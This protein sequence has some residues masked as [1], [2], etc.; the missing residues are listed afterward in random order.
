M[1]E[2]HLLKKNTV[3]N[4]IVPDFIDTLYNNALLLVLWQLSS[5]IHYVRDF[6]RKVLSMANARVNYYLFDDFTGVAPYQ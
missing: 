6:T 5:L 4:K 1:I 3:I 2:C